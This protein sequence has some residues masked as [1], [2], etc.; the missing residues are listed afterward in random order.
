MI[1]RLGALTLLVIVWMALWGEL[2][3]ATAL[4]GVAVGTVAL[5]VGPRAEPGGTTRFRPLHLVRYL[6]FFLW[7]LVQATTSV[8]WEVV[9]PGTG[10]REGV[11]RVPVQDLSGGVVTIIA[12]TISLIPGTLT[13]EVRREPDPVLY[14]HVLHMQEVEEAREEIRR[15]E[16]RARAAFGVGPRDPWSA[17]SDPTAAT[18]STRRSGSQTGD[19]TPGEG[20]DQ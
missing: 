1:S 20:D 17:G 16:S 6:G 9:T 12:N 11:V 10:V 15:V 19:D 14:I 13:L 5:F 7:E 4:G 3:L 8:A 18:D 2:S